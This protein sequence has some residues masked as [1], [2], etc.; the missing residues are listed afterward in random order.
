MTPRVS[1]QSLRV[2]GTPCRGPT[3]SPRARASSARRASAS[4]PS[5]R[6]C[7]TALSA[8]LT[9]EILERN[10]CVSS[11]AETRFDRIAA[12]RSIAEL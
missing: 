7:T 6:H 10:A 3:S 5:S 12:A 8:G 11:T 9:A 2:I 1:K 4:A